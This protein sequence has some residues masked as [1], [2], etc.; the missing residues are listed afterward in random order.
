MR[1]WKLVTSISLVLGGFCAGVGLNL[2]SP[3]FT[4]HGASG[5]SDPP[6]SALKTVTHN[7]TLAGDGTTASPLGIANG[8]VGTVQIANGAVTSSKI[9]AASPMPG[10]LLSFNGTGLAWQAPSVAGVRVVD[11]LGHD[12]GPYDSSRS[13]LRRMGAFT[14]LLAVDQNGFTNGGISFAHTTS[15]CS[16]PRYLYGAGTSMVRASQ[17]NSTQVFFAADP[18]QV[19]HV[20]SYEDVQDPNQPG[21]CRGPFPPDYAF[22]V[23][24]ATS[25]SL[26]AL[27][28]TP[29][30]RLEF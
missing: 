21:S 16:G 4:V 6:P 19:L 20:G 15:D 22:S 3:N 11:S 27:G 18:L 17:N 9:G 5:P 29:P 8:G 2:I 28:L 10:Q 26:S 30:F 12:V 14:F 13:A 25:A 23:G 24:P 1:N 7:A